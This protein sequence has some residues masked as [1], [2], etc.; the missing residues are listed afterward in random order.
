MGL[1]N[2]QF[3]S[4]CLSNNTLPTGKKAYQTKVKDEHPVDIFVQTLPIIELPSGG[5]APSYMEKAKSSGKLAVDAN[6]RILLCKWSSGAFKNRFTG[7]IK[8][9]TDQRLLHDIRSDTSRNEKYG[10]LLEAAKETIPQALRRLVSSVTLVGLLRF[11]DAPA[12]DEYIYIAH[13]TASAANE[14]GEKCASGDGDSLNFHETVEFCEHPCFWFDWKEIPFREMPADDELWYPKVL[15]EKKKIKGSF[16]FGGW[17]EKEIK[18]YDL[19]T[20]DN[21]L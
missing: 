6:G 2:S 20:V 14:L 16:T 9:L 1:S 15:W 10:I 5:N 17:D 18:S 3:N 21:I 7:L 4:R 8:P 19:Y 13:L 12:C 11:E